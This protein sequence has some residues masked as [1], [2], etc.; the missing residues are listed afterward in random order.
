[1]TGLAMSSGTPWDF[2]VWKSHFFYILY[3]GG[4]DLHPIGFIKELLADEKQKIAALSI[5]S[6]TSLV[7]LKLIA[8]IVT[9]SVSII[10]EA[11]H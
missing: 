10:S 4:N 2:N 8:G 1:M 6:N 5:L 3:Q 7:L 9:N 11:I